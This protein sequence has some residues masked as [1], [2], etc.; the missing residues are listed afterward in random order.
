MVLCRDCFSSNKDTNNSQTE[1]C[2]FCNSKRIVIHS[3]LLSLSIAHIDCDSFYASVE[4]RDHPKLKS[5]PLVVGGNVRGVVAAACYVARQYGIRSA[6]PIFKAKKLC[7]DLTIIQPRMDMYQ[8]VGKKVRS[9]METITP[10]VQPISIDEAFLDLSGT[11]KLHKSMPAN[12]LVKLQKTIFNEIG[13]T[14]SI[15]LSFNKLLAKLASEQNKPNGFYVI[16]KKEAEKW[17]ANKP[18]SIILGLGKA[19]V[20]KL[21]KAGIYTC[22]NLASKNNL[23]L[24]P[25]LGKNTHKI[26]ELSCGID[27]RKVVLN[28]P[29]KSISV[30]TTFD[31]N[32]K[33]K[34]D[35]ENHLHLLS[36]KLSTRLKRSNFYGT[37]V[38]LKL[39][40]S[41]FSLKIRSIKLNEPIQLAHHLF[42]ISKRLLSKELNNEENYRLIGLGVSGL[43]KGEKNK[44]SSD[45]FNSDIDK[46]TKLEYVFD[47]INTKIGV[48]TLIMGRH[49]KND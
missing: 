20:S 15:G 18:V 41:D 23:I 29:E 22:G 10:L 46:K 25:I 6:M 3:E 4:K 26:K 45:L 35:L 36:N 43:Q 17:L 21:N 5:K 12:N 11:E 31:Y 37:T 47:K 33:N 13:I 28:G 32:I 14:V 42:S 39:K 30:E 24:K 44:F 48:N 16:G 1:E 7:P 27:P 49:M 34:S 40:L 2:Q 8:K 19:T 9:L 38:I